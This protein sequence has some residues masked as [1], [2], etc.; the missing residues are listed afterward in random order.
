MISFGGIWRYSVNM[1]HLYWVG[2]DVEMNVPSNTMSSL[3]I[4]TTDQKREQTVAPFDYRTVQLLRV[5]VNELL[6]VL[7]DAAP[8]ELTKESI[9]LH[10]DAWSDPSI[11]R[12]EN[13][14]GADGRNPRWP[15]VP[16]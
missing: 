13:S 4:V 1:S 8:K 2:R 15:I 3:S 6:D 16:V 10:L 11:S 7:L 9:T 12:L 5:L 14:C